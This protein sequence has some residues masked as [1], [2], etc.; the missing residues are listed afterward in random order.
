M[1][2]PSTGR[3]VRS[4]ILPVSAMGVVPT[5]LLLGGPPLQPTALGLLLG[6]PL[7]GAGLAMLGW[8]LSLFVRIGRGTLAPWDPTRKLVIVGPYAHVRNPMISGVWGGLV[9]EAL[10]LGSGR[11]ALWAA[12]FLLINHVYFVLSEEPGL[13]RRFGE[14][15]AQYCRAV[16]RWIPRWR[17]YPG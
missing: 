5:C 3:I 8:T 2:A 12:L 17:P 9:G 11:L 14:E 6:L 10:V 7:L 16:P 15:Y 4:L 1:T 13:L